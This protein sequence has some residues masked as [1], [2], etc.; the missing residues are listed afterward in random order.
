MNELIVRN[1]RELDNAINFDGIVIVQFGTWYDR[2]IVRSGY[3]YSVVARGNSSVEAWE[4]SS[5]VAW[6]NS[7][8]EAWGNSSV[9][10]RENSS[11]E[12]WGNS[13]VVAR[14]NSSVVAWGNSSVAGSG[15]SQIVDRSDRHNIKINGNSRIVYMPQT[16]QEYADFYGLD[17]DGEKIK[18]F[19]AVRKEGE[20]YRANFDPDFIYEIGKTVVPDYFDD[21]RHE[22]CSHGIH[23]AYPD[24]CVR[25][26][27][28]WDDLAIIE[29]EVSVEDVIVPCFSEGKVR[30]RK[31]TVIREVPLEE[32]GL[33]GRM[34]AKNNSG[35]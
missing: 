25:F 7:S 8:V 26:G 33:L 10:A 34:L 2:A 13:S 21:N 9:V 22:T 6:E 20:C 17:C 24:W 30:A 16:V 28:E 23:M 12:A 15:N 18:L 29:L 14:E 19:K 4:N 1:Q 5:V 35:E 32:C 3:K 11:V 31:A 27:R